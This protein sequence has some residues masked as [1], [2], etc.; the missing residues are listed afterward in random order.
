MRRQLL[1]VAAV[2]ALALSGCTEIPMSSAP[3]VVGSQ[4]LGVQV[5]PPNPPTPGETP[6]F[7]VSDFLTGNADSDPNHAGAR[8]YLTASESTRWSDDRVT[9][10]GSY[11]V[12]TT[13]R[14]DVINV[15]APVLGTVDATGIFTP[16][17]TGDGTGRA[18]EFKFQTKQVK[19]AKY[20]GPQW[21]ID[22]LLPGLIITSTRFQQQFQQRSI[23]FYDATEQHLVPDP[24][25]TSLVDPISLANWLLRTVAAGPRDAL[26]AAE[27]TELPQQTDPRRV[28]VQL[29]PDSNAPARIFIP[30]A[31]QLDTEARSHLAVQIAATLAQVAQIGTA[32]GLTIYDGD[33]KVAIPSVGTTFSASDFAAQ[34]SPAT[35]IPELYYVDGGGGVVDQNGHPL[36]GKVGSGFYDLVSVALTNGP[37]GLLIAGTRGTGAT[38]TLDIGSETTPLEPVPKVTGALSRPAWAPD[39]HEVWIGA[40][41]TL[42]RV[43]TRGVAHKVPMSTADGPAAGQILAVRFSPEG[44]RVAVVLRSTVS[45]SAATSQVYVGNVVRGNDAVQVI[46]LTPVTAADI[47]VRDVTWNDGLKL[48]AVGRDSSTNEAGYYE[49]QCD[50][51]RWSA[52]GIGNLP[53]EPDTITVASGHVLAVSV[54]DSVWLQS[55]A[56]WASPRGDETDG[57]APIYV[58]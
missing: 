49:V 14:V 8:Q 38:R 35:A 39:V 7:I 32:R 33:K 21:R 54:G 55:G 16:V 27:A 31:A 26:N 48:Y 53:D 44:S 17:L 15:D 24:R 6:L 22:K 3:E 23:Y 10:V 41:S 40:G 28:S 29:Q 25:Y 50:G 37:Q 2:A 13:S 9:V 43:S 34:I 58:E 4:G 52:R 51:S 57:T 45:G 30:G 1:A 42:Y 5:L 56:I 36:P 19:V 20:R 11:H 18:Q 47:I 12:G 46:G